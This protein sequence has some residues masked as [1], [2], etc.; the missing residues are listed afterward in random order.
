MKKDIA[1]NE[2]RWKT[3]AEIRVGHGETELLRKWQTGRRG[4]GRGVEREAL[5]RPT[6]HR[7]LGCLG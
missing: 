7:W 1:R 6:V 5:R 3:L 4:D 2:T